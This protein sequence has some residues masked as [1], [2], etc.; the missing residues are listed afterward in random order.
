MR[1]HSLFRTQR[2]NQSTRK[3]KEKTR[4]LTIYYST[5]GG[6]GRRRN[7]AYTRRGRLTYLKSQ[8][9]R[10]S[11]LSL[12]V[13]QNSSAASSLSCLFVLVPMPPSP[14][15][16]AARKG[17]RPGLNPPQKPP[18][19]LEIPLASAIPVRSRAAP[20]R[21]TAGGEGGLVWWGGRKWR[22]R[23]GVVWRRVCRAL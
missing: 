10:S 4:V 8:T 12:Q 23:L 5:I 1:D 20:Q 13:K 14:R 3:K 9:R 19:N 15:R 2:T 18:Q 16:A 6:S 7:R 21:K 22:R 11:P 17:N